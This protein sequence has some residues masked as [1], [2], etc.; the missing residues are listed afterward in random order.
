M[1]GKRKA[2]VEKQSDDFVKTTRT[3]KRSIARPLAA[4]MLK[5]PDLRLSVVSEGDGC[6]MDRDEQRRRLRAR[7]AFL[8]DLAAS[9]ALRAR[10]FPARARRARARERY[11]LT[12]F[13]R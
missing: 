5:S 8:Q 9:R 10:V 1:N 11:M 4:H 6:L 3:R 7:R 12:Y 2:S 13:L